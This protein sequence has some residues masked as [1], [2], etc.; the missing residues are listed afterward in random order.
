MSATIHFDRDRT[1]RTLLI[2]QAL[3]AAG[4]YKGEL[5]NWWG[6]ETQAAYNE[7]F[8]AQQ[9]AEPE[10]EWLTIARKELGTSEISGAKDNPRIVEYHATTGLSA[11]DDETPWCSSF[12]NW[13]MDRAGINGTDSAMA[14]SW[15]KWGHGIVQ[16]K[17][18]A[19]TV[20]TRGQYPAGHVA[21]YLSTD[22]DNIRVLGGNQGN[23]VS[24]ASYPKAKVLGY[25]WP[26]AV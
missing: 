11:S 18:G 13:C 12:V 22:G 2:Q 14:R 23:K 4:C 15:L 20:F 16:P 24:I 9:V 19:I 1:L 8:T 17:P 7:W 10:P 25:R 21:F 26:S 6:G 3:K 5:D